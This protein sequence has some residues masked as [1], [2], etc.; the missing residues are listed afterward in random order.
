[1]NVVATELA[2]YELHFVV[3]GDFKSIKLGIEKAVD[4]IFFF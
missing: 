4:V 1:M 3:V 2:K